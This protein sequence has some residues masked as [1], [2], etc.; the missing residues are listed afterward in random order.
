[1]GLRSAAI[2]VSLAVFL[3]QSGCSM[4]Q[5]PAETRQKSFNQF[6]MTAP[7]SPDFTEEE[8]DPYGYVGKMTGRPVEKD[9]DQWYRQ[10]FMSAKARNIERNLGQE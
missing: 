10:G 5:S 2:A 8:E 1:M 7:D 9:P 6:S 4:R 3:G